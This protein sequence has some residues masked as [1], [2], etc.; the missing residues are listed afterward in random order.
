M[1]TRDVTAAAGNHRKRGSLPAVWALLGLCLLAGSPRAVKG[2][3]NQILVAAAISLKES[4]NEIGAL[5]GRTTG[6]RVTF[7]FG[8]SGELEKQIEAGAPV[9]VFASAG[10][11]EM[12]QLQAKGLIDVGSR[13]NFARNLLVL[14]VP[15]DS[16]LHLS[17]ISDLA[18]PDVT[19]VAI[20]DPKTVPAGA[21]AREVLDKMQLWSRVESRLI[22]AQ[23]VRQVLDYV[24]RGEV[25]AGMVYA[26][27]VGVAGGKVAV[28][29]RAPEEDS[30]P[31]LY[32]V[33]IVKGSPKAAAAK[34][35][36][37]LVLAPEGAGILK[38]HGFLA[39]K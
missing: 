8:S 19:K 37:D 5:Y 23:N 26:T 28:A 11:R 25:D 30:S 34:A 27:D 4:F 33:A 20:G 17:S 24:S 9:D 18:G 31:I 16:K 6:N 13:A 21:Y 22:F 2:Q 29:A 3:S 1:T 39:V 15:S 32:P 36:V 35:F 12:D 38:S 10:Q 7:T 14:I